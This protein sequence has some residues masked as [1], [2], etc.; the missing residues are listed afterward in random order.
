V[1]QRELSI[2]G[3]REVVL[4]ADGRTE[5]YQGVTA[6]FQT[7]GE[8]VLSGAQGRRLTLA[9]SPLDASLLAAAFTAHAITWAEE[10]PYE[11]AWRPWTDQDPFL[12]PAAN[13]LLRARRD[14]VGKATKIQ[15]AH[16]LPH[17]RL[18]GRLRP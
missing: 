5:R 6:A 2:I 12:A 10:D 15:E 3:S 17:P 16:H 1:G 14:L 9:P 13:A 8:L 18:Y 11:A 4:A 7:G